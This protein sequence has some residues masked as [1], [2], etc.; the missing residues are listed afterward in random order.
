[1]ASM[2]QPST[3]DTYG[4]D[5]STGTYGAVGTTTG[6]APVSDYPAA[7][8]TPASTSGFGTDTTT[9]GGFSSAADDPD[10]LFGTHSTHASTDS[11]STG[12][13]GQ[14]TQDTP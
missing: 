3:A 1:M 13:S 11:S 9:G 2:G 14:R 7:P 6:T 12:L 4:S 8:A 10:P 5:Y